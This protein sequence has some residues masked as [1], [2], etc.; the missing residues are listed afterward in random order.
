MYTK[1]IKRKI[2]QFSMC[3]L[4]KN[5]FILHIKM[6]TSKNPTFYEVFYEVKLLTI[7]RFFLWLT[8]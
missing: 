8:S 4:H 5:F 2:L 6:A 3:L 7:E 1:V